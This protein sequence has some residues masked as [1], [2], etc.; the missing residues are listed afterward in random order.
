MFAAADAG[1]KPRAT[2]GSDP[3]ALGE[4]HL[5]HLSLRHPAARRHAVREPDV[6]TDDRPRPDPDPPQD[7]RPPVD[8]HVVLDDRMAGDALDQLPVL[9]HGEAA[10]AER[11]AGPEE[12]AIFD[13]QISI[14]SDNE[15]IQRVESLIHQNIAA[16]KAFD[17][18]MIEWRQH[19]ARHTQPMIRERVSDLT[20]VHIRVL[21]ILLGL[22]DHDPV[23]VP[24]GTNAILVTHDLTPSLTVQ[25]DRE[26]IGA[27]AT[28]A[29]TRTSHVA[30]LARSLGL[31]AV[32]GLR[33]ATSR[34]HAGQ[35]AILDGSSG[36][37]IPDPSP[38]QIEA[39]TD[40]AIR[41]A[42]DE[43]ELKGLIGAEPVTL[44]GVAQA[45]GG[46]DED[47]DGA[48]RR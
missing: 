46:P 5:P 6:A 3:S 21:T 9:V 36:L 20:D 16:E 22:P 35:Q 15:L 8:H 37:L 24:K 40:R 12:A 18:V 2:P 23:D 29:G 30:I 19:F 44:D 13:V 39:Y 48:D 27:I 26:A 34:L 33:D 25:L 14:L 10:R 45:P 17:L 32:V 47:R 43:A 7:R 4:Q 41:E 1:R 38:S 11:H 28:D 42:A 31:P